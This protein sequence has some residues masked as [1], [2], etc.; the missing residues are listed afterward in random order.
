MKMHLKLNDE[1]KGVMADFTKLRDELTALE[2]ENQRI[3]QISLMKQVRE[4]SNPSGMVMQT[5]INNLSRENANLMAQLAEKDRRINGL[6]DDLAGTARNPTENELRSQLVQLQIQN[7]SLS[8]GEGQAKRDNQQLRQDLDVARENLRSAEVRLR[9]MERNAQSPLNRASPAQLAELDKL[10]VENRSLQSQ[11]QAMGDVPNRDRLE[12]QIRDL[13]KQNMTYQM[14]LDREKIMVGD[15]KKQLPDARSIR[16]EV[17]ER[18]KSANMKVELLNQE[19][20]DARSRVTSLEK[21]LVAARE[22]I[23]VLQSGGSERTL[24]PVS[25]PTSSFGTNIGRTGS[26]LGDF[27]RNS[28]LPSRRIQ[29]PDSLGDRSSMLQRET[30]EPSP[31]SSSRSPSARVQNSA[32]GIPICSYRRRYNFWIIRTVPLDLPNFSWWRMISIP[33]LPMKA[34]RC[35]QEPAFRAQ[36]NTG[37][38]PY[39]VD[40]GSPEWQPRFVMPSPVPA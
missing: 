8:K 17:L 10:K 1:F 9:E 7:Q 12:T 31:F 35:P 32:Q 13:N 37:H 38:A 34:F 39:S 4:T 15:L 24:I 6:R 29:L 18:G 11:L 27:N 36:R 19:L 33:S 5:E 2:A 30:F 25:N 14:Q 28:Y 20:G 40:T 22:A 23:R 21:A 16:Q 26:S 3:R